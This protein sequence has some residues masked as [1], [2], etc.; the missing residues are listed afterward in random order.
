MKLSEL[1]GRA[2]L[3]Y[4][5]EYGETEIKNIVTNSEKVEKGSLYICI[6]GLRFDGHSRI[7]GAIKKGAS[8]IVCERGRD[9]FVGGAAIVTVENTRA[10]TARLYN[11]WYGDPTA[12]MKVVGITGTNGKTSVACMLHSVFE[13]S[14]Y[15]CG[16]IG[17][18]GCRACG[19]EIGAESADALANMT[20]PDPEILYKIL[21]EMASLGTQFVFMEVSSHSLSLSKCDA[22]KFDGAVFTNL[23]QDH[24]DFHSDMEEYFKAKQRLFSMSPLAV[25]NA[26]DAYGRR[27]LKSALGKRVSTSLFGRGDYTAENIKRE[28]NASYSYDLNAKGKRY[29]LKL[30]VGGEFAVNNSLQAAALAIEFGL[31]AD[32]VSLALSKIPAIAGRMELVE[33]KYDTGFSVYIDYAHTP[34]ALENILGSASRARKNGER[35]ILVFGCGGDRD[36]GKRAQMGRIASRYS[37]L[38]VVTSDNSRS[39][40]PKQIFSDI[41]KGIDKEKP[42][43]VIEDRCAAVEYAVES[44]RAGDIVVLAGKGHEKYEIDKT[45]RHPF[46]ERKIVINAIERRFKRTQ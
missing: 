28:K 22:V 23:T 9:V 40:E 41:L 39:E 44:A 18:V 33:S 37:D 15:R 12:K 10:I 26:D 32:R 46:D 6:K 30:S 5:C 8:A 25:I 7:D 21:G 27:V 16:L 31:P 19:V 38:V 43:A 42:Y 45:G 36:R 14:G 3:E 13:Q 35:I 11:A 2:E 24:L 17:T 1:F 29:P 4:P 34:D 20:T